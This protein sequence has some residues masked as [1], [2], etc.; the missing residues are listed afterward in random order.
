MDKQLQK[1]RPKAIV[2]PFR[3][4]KQ[5]F[6]GGVGMGLH[7]LLGNIMILNRGLAEMWF[8]WRT[9]KIFSERDAFMSYC[10]NEAGGDSRSQRES[11]PVARKIPGVISYSDRP[12]LKPRTPSC[13]NSNE[14]L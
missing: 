6:E 11:A 1:G 14:R 13:L 12:N 7:F 4:K 3:S 5:G 8:G 2:L 10:R 9:K